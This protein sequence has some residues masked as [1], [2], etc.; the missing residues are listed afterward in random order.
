[1]A[2]VIDD[3]Y[4]F[5]AE[6]SRKSIGKM[7]CGKVA[8]LDGLIVDHFYYSHCLIL[9]IRVLAKLFNMMMHVGHVPQRFRVSDSRTLYRY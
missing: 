8:D 5:D 9:C 1:M 3:S 6:T 4:T 2:S 7:K